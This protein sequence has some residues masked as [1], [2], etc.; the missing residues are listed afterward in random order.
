M[1][2]QTLRTAAIRQTLHAQMEEVAGSVVLT[3][4]LAPL[5]VGSET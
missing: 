3:T 5:V 2:A 1:A 4:L